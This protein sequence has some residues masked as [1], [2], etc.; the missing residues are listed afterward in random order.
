MCKSILGRCEHENNT[1]LCEEF[2][3]AVTEREHSACCTQYMLPHLGVAV[4]KP[5][6]TIHLLCW[7]LY[8]NGELLGADTGLYLNNH[9][10]IE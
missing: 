8:P 1:P 9:K 6:T 3:C 10:Y 7:I 4:Q 5:N 2:M